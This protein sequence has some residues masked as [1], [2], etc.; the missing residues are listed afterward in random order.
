MNEHLF[1]DG[2][3]GVCHWA[4]RFVAE[5]DRRGHFRFAPLDGDTFRQSVPDAAQNTLPDSIVVTTDDGRLLV[6]STAV[7]HILW[8]LGGLWRP[9][10]AVLAVIPRA[11]RDAGYA[12]FARIRKR[13]VA[14]PEG[15]CPLMPPELGRR[16]DP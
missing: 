8:R 2:T 4:V 1:Y 5:R 7:I 13:L 9:V 6:R 15:A 12:S 10:A 3:C 11:L 16:F 14:A